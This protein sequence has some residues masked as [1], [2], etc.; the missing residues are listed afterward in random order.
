MRSSAS[1]LGLYAAEANVMTM[2]KSI[3]SNNSHLSENVK[4]S[5]MAL[6]TERLPLRLKMIYSF[7]IGST[8]AFYLD[9]YNY[10]LHYNFLVMYT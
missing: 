9:I 3:L 6:Y 5:Q 4:I 10:C 2:L 8:S 1:E 7:Y